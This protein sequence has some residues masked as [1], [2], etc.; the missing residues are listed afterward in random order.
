MDLLEIKREKKVC[1]QWKQGK[2]VSFTHVND[3]KAGRNNIGPL[4]DEGGHLTNTNMD[5]SKMFNA[6][7]AFIF[8]TS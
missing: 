6:L 2:K 3:K 7:L 4:Q 8:N 1:A 5:K